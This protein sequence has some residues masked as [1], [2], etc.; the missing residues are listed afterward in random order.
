MEY[1]TH[2]HA[3]SVRLRRKNAAGTAVVVIL[4]LGLIAAIVALSPLGTF[5]SDNV[6]V[7][8]FQWFK[9][10][11]PD[12]KIVSA[13]SQ[14][15]NS[16]SA[17]PSAAPTEQPPKEIVLNVDEKPFYILQMGVF[18]DELAAEEHAE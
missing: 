9:G 16:A 11:D 18:T 4:S 6:F 3:R 13:L 15:E 5:L 7:P 2:T 14:Q 8:L 12:Q 1:R 10:E 17:S